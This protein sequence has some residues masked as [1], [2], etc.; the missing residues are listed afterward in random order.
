MVQLGIQPEKTARKGPL[1]TLITINYNSMSKLEIILTCLK[2]VLEL[3]WRPLQLVYIDNGSTDQSFSKIQEFAKQNAPEDIDLIFLP[4]R[5]NLGFAKGNNEGLRASDPSSKYIVILNNDLAPKPYSLNR[6]VEFL[7]SHSDFAGV[8]PVVMCWDDAEIDS[9]GGVFTFWGASGIAKGLPKWY[10]KEPFLVSHV[11][12]AYS[13]YRKSA[14]ERAGG[15]FLPDFFMYGD[16]YE[17]GVRLWSNGYKLAALPVDGGRHYVSATTGMS[18]TS[19]YFSMRNETSVLVM[20]SGTF[21]FLVI[22]RSIGVVGY[23][24]AKRRRGAARA[25]IDGLVFGREMRKN[26]PRK[27]KNAMKYVPRPNFSFT[28]F[29]FM[30]SRL[31]SSTQFQKNLSDRITNSYNL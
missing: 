23:S 21:S 13:V 22:T 19:A 18:G 27:M 31:R 2:S 20:Y 1:V 30:H 14:I 26:M 17:L 29:V 25:F 6:L 10:A 5:A 28:D 9:A 7:E 15:L 3:Q 11:Y 12:G 16:D 24:F 4:L 8:Q